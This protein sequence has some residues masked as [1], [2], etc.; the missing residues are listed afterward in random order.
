MY[1]KKKFMHAV[2]YVRH[3]G[4][5]MK[6]EAYL[7]ML[8]TAVWESPVPIYI[9]HVEV[10]EAGKPVD[11]RFAYANEAEARHLSTPLEKLLGSS[12]IE[13]LPKIGE[14][15]LLPIRKFLL[16]RQRLFDIQTVTEDPLLHDLHRICLEVGEINRRVI[17]TQRF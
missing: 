12:G 15:W 17:Q 5:M 7:K 9:I 2:F 16:R 14:K 11:W 6:D 4:D 13:L 1:N 10:D 3:K 8:G